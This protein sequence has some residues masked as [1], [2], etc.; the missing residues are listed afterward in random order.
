MLA[1]ASLFALAPLAWSLPVAARGPARAVPSGA[2]RLTRRVERELVDGR[3]LSVSREWRCNF[4]AAGRG[5][6]VLGQQ[7]AC[8]VEAPAALSPLAELERRRPDPGPFPAML[9]A[10]GMIIGA[11][12]VPPMDM[13]GAIAAAAGMLGAKAGAE[14]RAFMASLGAMAAQQASEIPADLFFPGIAEQSAERAV[15]LADGETGTIAVHATSVIDAESGLL[16]RRRL[17]ITTQVGAVSRTS[18]ESWTLE[19]M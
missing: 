8:Q 2:F 13:A 4:A 7:T 15:T 14:E 6:E 17:A 12:A 16:R 1:R 9:D 18:G 10:A 19:R 11:A 3:M 5:M